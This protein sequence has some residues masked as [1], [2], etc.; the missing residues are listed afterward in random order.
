ME[1]SNPCFG[2]NAWC[3]RHAIDVKPI[4]DRADE[5]YALTRGYNIITI[6]EKRFMWK[7]YENQCPKLDDK[8]GECTIYEKRPD[9]CRNRPT[10]IDLGFYP[11]KCG[12]KKKPF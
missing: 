1:Q 6:E 9:Y 5:E 3:C 4:I 12:Y 10:D 2:C 8:T 7:A 11:F